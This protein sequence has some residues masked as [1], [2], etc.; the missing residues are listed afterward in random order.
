MTRRTSIVEQLGAYFA[1]KGKVLTAEEY[2]AEEDVPVR[3][4]LVKR[5]IGSWSRVINMIGDLSQYNGKTVVTPEPT[6]V[7]TVEEVPTVETVEAPAKPE[8]KPAVEKTKGA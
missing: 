4:Q 1:S 3:F 5:N 2:K 7:T 6:V 8:V